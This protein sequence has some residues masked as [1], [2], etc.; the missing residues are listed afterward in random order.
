MRQD[1]NPFIMIG[2]LTTTINAAKR[3]REARQGSPER[4]GR[5]GHGANFPSPQCFEQRASS[6]EDE[7]RQ[8]NFKSLQGYAQLCSTHLADIQMVA[9]ISACPD[10]NDRKR[11]AS[12]AQFRSAKRP[13]AERHLGRCVVAGWPDGCT[14][15]RDMDRVI[16]VF[17]CPGP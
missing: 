7:T 12:P 8:L 6:Y 9:R 3:W 17:A 15:E 4:S 10:Q 14:I 16:G 5:S 13:L 2:G 1:R 11:Q